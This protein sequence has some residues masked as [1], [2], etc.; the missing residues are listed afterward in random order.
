MTVY[1]C[2]DGVLVAKQHLPNGIRP[3]A[4]DFPSP[5]VSRFEAYQSPVTDR[6]ISS[7]R[8]R[9]VDLF[10]SNSYDERDIGPNHPIAKA[11]KARKQANAVARS[12][13]PEPDFWR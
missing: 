13:G 9:E 6:T 7:D 3:A 1:V 12:T 11:K 8:Q 4:S 2:R 5:R 10:Q